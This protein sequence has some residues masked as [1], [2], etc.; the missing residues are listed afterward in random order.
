MPDR[1]LFIGRFQP[2]HKGHLD[3]VGRL[4]GAHDELVVGIGSANVSHTAVN[5]FTAGERLMMIR[6][7]CADAGIGNVI[8]VPIPDVGRNAIWVSHV[9][10]LVPRVSIVYS[11]NPLPTRLFREA[12]Y[13]T[14]PAPF[15]EREKYE[16]T[17]IRRL[18]ETQ[19]DAW[20]DLVPAGV[21]R[22]VEELDLLAR[23]RDLRGEAPKVEGHDPTV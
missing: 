2:F 7:A 12:R 9:T 20:R 18:M 13:E 19:D 3:V 11:N 4:A 16:G 6:A 14:A 23:L 5:P 15:H 17:R 22:V 10:S 8:V 1:G 21:A